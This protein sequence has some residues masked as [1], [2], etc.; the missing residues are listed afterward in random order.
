MVAWYLVGIA[1]LMSALFLKIKWVSLLV[2]LGCFMMYFD[3]LN[4]PWITFIIFILG[5]IFLII[6]LYV[7][8]FGVMGVVGFLTVAIALYMKLGSVSELIML[9]IYTMLVIGCVIIIGFKLGYNLRLS[10]QFVLKTELNDQS[11]YAA[12]KV[13]NETLLNKEAKVIESL[14]PVGKIRLDGSGETYQVI[15]QDGF[16]NKG[17]NVQIF[18]IKDA[19][20][21][22]RKITI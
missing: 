19:Q 3:V 6:E 20:I 10:P 1:A 2:A 8:D 21:Y 18:E 7:P 11:G 15:S 17:E 4:Q 9:T 22:V 13:A 5:V 14:R 16:I 12:V